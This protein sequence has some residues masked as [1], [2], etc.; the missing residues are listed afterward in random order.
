MKGQ[1]P[2]NDDEDDDEDG[3][4]DQLQVWELGDEVSSD[5]GGMEEPLAVRLVNN[6]TLQYYI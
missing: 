6:L 1:L 4:G 5:P 2:D 3:G